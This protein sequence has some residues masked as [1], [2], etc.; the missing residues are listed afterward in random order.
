MKE[1]EEDTNKWEDSLC[2]W[3]GRIN[4]VQINVHTT[5]S[6]LQIQCNLYQNSN[7][8][9]YR[10]RTNNSKICT[11]QQKTS[12]SQS[13]PEKEEQSWSIICPDFKLYYKAIV[14]KTVWYWH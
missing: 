11:E 9:F 4:I 6:D 10:T 2:S 5:Q 1:Y 8:M 12:N 3:I 13:N 14:I 7:A